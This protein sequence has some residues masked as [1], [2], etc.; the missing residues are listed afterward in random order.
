MINSMAKFDMRTSVE[1]TKKERPVPPFL[2][3]PK[4]Y[5]A[6]NLWLVEPETS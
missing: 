1:M 6:T 3:P 5:T 2:C 4:N